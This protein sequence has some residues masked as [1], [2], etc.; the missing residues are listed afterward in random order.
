MNK[1]SDFESSIL[2]ETDAMG[3]EIWWTDAG[4]PSDPA[5]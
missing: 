2:S 1:Q 3:R 5:K 4:R